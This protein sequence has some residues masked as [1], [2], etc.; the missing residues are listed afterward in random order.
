MSW[1]VVCPE[2]GG[3]V[4]GVEYAYGS[5]DRYD[6]A[7]EWACMDSSCGTRVGRW[8][9]NRLTGTQTEPRFGGPNGDGR[10][11]AGDRT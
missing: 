9:G 10:E 4:A 7:S 6:G 1:D 5:P 3:E 8:T 2:C 11:W